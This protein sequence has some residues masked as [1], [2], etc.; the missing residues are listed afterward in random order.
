MSLINTVVYLKNE[1]PPQDTTHTIGYSP[2]HLLPSSP[3]I[4]PAPRA[5]GCLQSLFPPLSAHLASRSPGL[6][7]FPLVTWG[8]GAWNL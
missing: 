3:P 4:L 7:G 2:E 5:R 1:S 6:G 8:A